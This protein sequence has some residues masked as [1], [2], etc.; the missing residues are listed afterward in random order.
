MLDASIRNVTCPASGRSGYDFDTGR[1]S[2]FPWSTS[3]S[4]SVVIIVSPVL[5]SRKC[6]SR[7][8][9]HTRH[10]LT[11]RAGEHLLATDPYAE[12]ETTDGLVPVHIADVAKHLG[13]EPVPTR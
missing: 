9:G 4:S 10:L 5:P 3:R 8:V 7:V 12:D 6:T 2:I 13:G 11:H 1:I